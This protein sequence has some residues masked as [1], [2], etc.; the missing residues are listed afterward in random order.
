MIL[1]HADPD[2]VAAI[3]EAA[4]LGTS[5]GAPTEGEIRMAEDVRGA[6]PHM[7][8]SRMVSSGTEATMGALRLARGLH[9]PQ[10]R[11]EVH[12]RLPR[13][14]R[15]LAREGGKRPRDLR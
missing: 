3:A 4:A 15:L 5:Y 12:R 14:R 7:E 1:G 8:M 2:V 9:R 10:R 11:R 6:Y 13:R